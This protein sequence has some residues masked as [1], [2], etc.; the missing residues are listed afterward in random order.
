[1]I[2]CGVGLS[3]R[4]GVMIAQETQAVGLSVESLGHLNYLRGVLTQPL[5]SWDGF[6]QAQSPSMNFALR[7]QLAFATYALAGLAQRTPS[8]RA[9]YVEAMRAAIERM[10]RVEAWGY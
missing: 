10:L 7:Y 6:Y 9:P 2:Y 5:D 4:G 8:Y 3:S 1:M